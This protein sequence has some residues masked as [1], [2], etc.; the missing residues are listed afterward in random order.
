MY[1]KK[2]AK[3]LMILVI[4]LCMMSTAAWATDLTGSG[5]ENDPYVYEVG[6]ADALAD[7]V[8]NINKQGAGVYVISLTD[9]IDAAKGLSFS[10]SGTKVTLLGNGHSI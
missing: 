8:K 2:W 5:T 10:G 1:R 4:A 7:A 3:S 6:T 9:D